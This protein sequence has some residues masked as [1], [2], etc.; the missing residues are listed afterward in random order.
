MLPFKESIARLCES[1]TA[2]KSDQCKAVSHQKAKR[3]DTTCLSICEKTN[4]IKSKV[5]PLHFSD[6]RNWQN[7]S[8]EIQPCGGAAEI[9]GSCRRSH[10]H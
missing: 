8:W 6:W 2:L 7:G 10:P 1:Q 9:G 5:L 4:N 3:N